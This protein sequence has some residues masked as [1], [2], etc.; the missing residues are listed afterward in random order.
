[1]LQQHEQTYP[2]CRSLDPSAILTTGSESAYQASDGLLNTLL[3]FTPTLNL[4]SELEVYS[5]TPI[6]QTSKVRLRKFQELDELAQPVKGRAESRAPT[7]SRPL[8]QGVARP[9]SEAFCRGLSLSP[10]HPLGVRGSSLRF[11]FAKMN[12]VIAQRILMA[13]DLRL[14]GLLSFD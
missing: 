13:S 1:M 4:C 10:Q 5:I 8:R 2:E 9:R 3:V 14:S 6:R 7:E 12:K 11:A